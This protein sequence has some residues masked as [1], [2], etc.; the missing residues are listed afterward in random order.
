MNLKVDQERLTH[1]KVDRDKSG[2][3]SRLP[4]SASRFTSD[5]SHPGLQLREQIAADRT[6]LS[7][8][9]AEAEKLQE[10]V[11]E[12]TR[13]NQQFYE[14]ATTF[15]AIFE[16]A[17]S[18]TNQKQMYENNQQSLKRTI[19]LLK[20]RG[21]PLVVFRQTFHADKS[22]APH[23]NLM[24]SW[25][26]SCETSSETLPTSRKSK[27][28]SSVRKSSEPRSCRASELDRGRRPVFWVRGR[29]TER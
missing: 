17:Q 22:S 25:K 7:Q 27:S 20:G 2:R 3:V 10:E 28:R 21:C 19:K 12:L 9:E 15:T 14:K 1:L 6:K 23:Q 16:K 4:S 8:K 24:K 13:A 29:L 26:N 11:K 18:L 5:F